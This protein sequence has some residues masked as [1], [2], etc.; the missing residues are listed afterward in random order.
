M[1]HLVEGLELLIRKVACMKYDATGLVPWS[2][3]TIQFKRKFCIYIGT[4]THTDKYVLQ[5]D[6][7]TEQYVK[8]IK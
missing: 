2:N 1:G 4:H 6:I 3:Y 5:I 8:R 7:L